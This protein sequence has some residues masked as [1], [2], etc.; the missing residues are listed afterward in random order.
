MVN[1][2]HGYY[3]QVFSTLHRTVSL[4]TAPQLPHKLMVKAESDRS[5]DKITKRRKARNIGTFPCPECSKVF[6]RSD[7]LARHYLNHQ[8]KEVYVCN[9]IIKGPDGERQPCGKTFVRKDLRERHVKR[10]ILLQDSVK[11]EDDNDAQATPREQTTPASDLKAPLPPSAGSMNSALGHAQHPALIHQHMMGHMPPYRAPAGISRPDGPNML[12]PPQIPVQMALQKGAHLPQVAQVA[13]VAQM[14]QVLQMSQLPQMPQM[15]QM[16]QISHVSPMPLMS[17]QTQPQLMPPHMPLSSLLGS[18]QLSPQ[19]QRLAPHQ[20]AFAGHFSPGYG[21]PHS[22]DQAAYVHEAVQAAQVAQA[23]Q[24]AQNQSVQ[25]VQTAQTA[26]N[27]QTGQ[28]AQGDQTAQTVPNPLAVLAD[29]NQ[30]SGV[31]AGATLAPISTPDAQDSVP[32]KPLQHMGPPQSV[33]ADGKQAMASDSSR[34]TFPQSQND[35]LSWLFMES[36]EIPRVLG[37][38][39]SDRQSSDSRPMD[40]YTHLSPQT[41][42]L[43]TDRSIYED[44]LGLLTP[45]YHNP[46]ELNVGL[47]DLNFFL[48]SDNPLDEVFLRSQSDNIGRSGDKPASVGVSLYPST[49]SSSSPTNTN[50]SATPRT[51]DLSPQ[52]AELESIEK[53]LE[54]H[55]RV[56][57]PSNKQFYVS[58]EILEGML[59]ALPDLTRDRLNEIF[60]IDKDRFSLEDRLSL[61]LY[62]YWEAFHTRFSILHK[63]SFDTSAAEPLLLLSMLLIGC[64]YCADSMADSENHR[65]CPEYKFCMLVA[66]PLRFTLFQHKDFKSPVKVW[67][68]QSLN[69]L[70]WCEKNYLLRAMHER[71]H[72]HHGTTVQLLRRSPF[73]GGNP[74]VTN[75]AVTS[76]SD[77]G[78]S[79]GEED[80]SDG[81]SD[82][83]EASSRDTI[84][85]K[86][87]VESESMKRVTFM[88]FYL[89]VID[90][91]KFRH[92][93]QI[94]FFQLQLLNL[95]CD[96]EALWNSEDVNSSF[97]KIVKRQKKLLRLGHGMRK[98]KEHGR[99]RSGMN[100]LTAL[101]RIMRSQ[102]VSSGNQKLPTFTK[103][104]LFGGLVSIMHQMQ[105]AEL[106]K[107]FTLLMATERTEK[108]KNQV[109]KEILTKVF[110]TWEAEMHAFDVNFTNDAFFGIQK[111]QCKFPMYH[112]AQIVGISDINHYDIAI[113]GG[114]PG[115]M[116]VEATSKDL[117]IVQRKMT[118]IW[119]QNS[120]ITSVGDLVN[121]KSVIHCYWLLWSLMLAPM[122]PDADSYSSTTYGWRVDHDY[123]DAMY[124]VSIATLVLWCYTYTSNG[125]ESVVFKDLESTMPLDDQRNYDKIRDFAKEDGYQYLFRIRQEFM[126]LLSKEGL[127]EEYILHTTQPRSPL[128]PLY[129]VIGKYCELLP[130]IKGKQN[131]SGLCFLVGTNLLKSQW[132]VIRENAKLIINCGLRS[133]GKRSVQCPDLFD[134]AFDN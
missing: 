20:M 112:L 119:A 17:P 109:W 38:E 36:S 79:G 131:I 28:S 71:A 53:R 7:H 128:V 104:I 84:L 52:A 31:F 90:Y 41:L 111:G 91:I 16:S 56:N 65:M 106:Q 62:G 26:Q 30:S 14:P 122:G 107:N 124:A 42:R 21:V 48:N 32:L 9:H 125:T 70:E 82:I 4:Q 117:S 114:S 47:Q 45:F 50:E 61:Y 129:N 130:Q 134:N 8:P 67:I 96:D 33:R 22:P 78:A 19:F 105:Q 60:P 5:D 44:D 29:V 73:L 85:F 40:I 95:P 99:V 102:R 75:K 59:R 80:V 18:S 37:K 83:E 6:T 115:N 10:H 3:T 132:Q 1:V 69:L 25:S 49:A 2:R 120:K 51:A 34:N 101:K 94:P 12:V 127:L 133:V 116:S 57:K 89:D 123:F 88:T 126:Q 77:T 27:V 97:R 24:S 13:Q 39:A 108:H 110:D 76:A 46:P 43:I 68:L 35:I 58:S 92:N 54:A 100:F 23:A 103:S 15:S 74:T 11:P 87:W 121:F 98:V 66:V 64:M 81:A 55:V 63:P 118:S 93:P 113:F 72:I 86:R